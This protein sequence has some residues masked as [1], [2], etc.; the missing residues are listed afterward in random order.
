M[1]GIG[2]RTSL[3]KVEQFQ[4]NIGEAYNWLDT[5]DDTF[6]KIG[7]AM[8]R[9]NE[10]VVN[11]ANGTNTPEDRLKIQSELDQIREH[12]QN[13]ANTKVGDKY[14]FSGTKRRLHSMM[15]LAIQQ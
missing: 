10:L 12:I 9:A 6:D 8:Q 13:L 4:R 3:D 2:Y 1:K 7:S 14:I 11:A 15:V 5:S